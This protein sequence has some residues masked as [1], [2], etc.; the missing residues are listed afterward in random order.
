MGSRFPANPPLGYDVANR[1]RVVN[2]AETETVQHIF[3]RYLEVG[4]ARLLCAGL[5]Q[6]GIVSK[7]RVFQS[8]DQRGGKALNGH[9]TWPRT[10]CS[11]GPGI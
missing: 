5:A 3:Q 9:A 11:D 7:R 10:D 2:E 8:G 6:A 4:C 1:E